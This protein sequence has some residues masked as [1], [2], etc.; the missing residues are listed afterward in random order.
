MAAMGRVHDG[1]LRLWHHGSIIHE[2]YSCVCLANWIKPKV[3]VFPPLGRKKLMKT[4]NL[5]WIANVGIF[6]SKQSTWFHCLACFGG[7]F[8]KIQSAPE[9][10]REQGWW[11]SIF[12]PFGNQLTI[13]QTSLFRMNINFTAQWS[14]K[15]KKRV[16]FCDEWPLRKQ[17]KALAKLCSPGKH[18]IGRRH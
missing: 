17:T 9:D 15:A 5:I 16:W 8:N 1:S 11:I 10:I 6:V 3:T 13:V 4:M 12:M 7:K 18:S 14:R 2:S